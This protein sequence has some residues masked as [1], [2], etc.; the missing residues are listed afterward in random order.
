MTGSDHTPDDVDLDLLFAEAKT[1]QPVVSD[2]LLA[3][4]AED[5]VEQQQKRTPHAPQPR[6]VLHQLLDALG[7]WPTLG[8]L[9]A[10][11]VTGVY[12]GFV[13]PELIGDTLVEDAEFVSADLW[14]GDDL[15]FEEG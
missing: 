14:P 6:G 2:G 8:G 3:R 11:A 1:V 4:I 15:F 10:T 9:A 7:G 13:Q 12:I 5:A